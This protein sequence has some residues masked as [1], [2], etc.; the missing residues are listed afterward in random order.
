MG[1]GLFLLVLFTQGRKETPF[2]RRIYQQ[3]KKPFID[4][5]LNGV[6]I[7][8]RSKASDLENIVYWRN[9]KE[10]IYRDLQTAGESRYEV[11]WNEPVHVGDTIRKEKG[12]NGFSL[13]R[14]NGR[15]YQSDR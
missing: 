1:L 13:F 6:I 10:I 8:V 5:E 2:S 9:A 3:Y 14:V 11:D 15:V 4:A 12:Q 7:D